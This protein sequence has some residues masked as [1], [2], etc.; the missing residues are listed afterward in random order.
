MMKKDSNK[1]KH[2]VTSSALVA[3]VILITI[4]LNAFV[5]VLADKVSLQVDLTANGIYEMSEQTSEFLK[6]YDTPTE[7]YFLASEA[8]QDGAVQILQTLLE[9]YKVKNSNIKLTNINISENPTFG[10]KYVTDGQSLYDGSV[11][12][13]AGERFRVLTLT[14]LYDINTQTNGVTGIKAE[15]KITS[16]LKYVSSDRQFTVYFV[17]GHNEMDLKGA[18]TKLAEENYITKDLS[19][20]NEEIPEDATMLV[21][22]APLD[23]LTPAELAKLDVYLKNGGHAQFLFDPNGSGLTNI[24]DYLKGWGITINDNL[25]V[26]DDTSKLLSLGNTSMF[27]VESELASSPL[28]QSMIDNKRTIA[29]Y[30]YSKSIDVTPVTNIE[31]QVLLTSTENAYTTTN[32]DNVSKT[33]NDPSGKFTV[34]A[35]AKNKDTGASI[36]VS[37]N[38][39]LL[40]I[41]PDI[42]TNSYGFEN[43]DFYMSLLR[44]AQGEEGAAVI[45]SKSLLG[46][47]LNLTVRQGR[48]MGIFAIAVIPLVILVV[49][50]LVWFRRRHL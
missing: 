27:L 3:I 37:G 22:A 35:L 10:K 43:Y 18:K 40:S 8:G 7:I 28:T 11:I 19:L 14:D 6:A 2:R 13:D 24:Y 47:Q 21:I 48:A 16:A 1:L 45:S 39:L 25:V 31:T 50:I 29:Y 17:N 15:S 20:Q 41:E 32:Y 23:D 38:T 4:A 26:E 12:I 49:G 34:T 44:T 33:E 46:S 36:L 9:Q 42:I 30:P 5:S